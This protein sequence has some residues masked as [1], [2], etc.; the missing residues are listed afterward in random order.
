MGS[1]ASVRPPVCSAGFRGHSGTAVDI[2]SVFIKVEIFRVLF[3]NQI[4]V[5]VFPMHR[6]NRSG[7]RN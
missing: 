2:I 3:R 5:S 4:S 6:L 7:V 1:G